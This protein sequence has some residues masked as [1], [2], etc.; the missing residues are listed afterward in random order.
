MAILVIFGLV[1]FVMVWFGFV[2]YD[3]WVL[4]RHTTM[5]ISSFEL[6]AILVILGFVWFG[7][8]WVGLVLYGM[9]CEYCLDIL[10]CKI[11]SF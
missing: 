11:S 7:M 6:L 1:W 8:V 4:Y 9:I 10:P 3:M 5:G 2:W